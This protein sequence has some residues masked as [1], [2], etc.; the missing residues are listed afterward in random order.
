MKIKFDKVS[1]RYDDDS[2]VLICNEE[3]KL[4]KL[5]N[6]NLK[7]FAFQNLVTHLRS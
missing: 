3:G 2:V 4:K 6:K 1:F 7:S 5:Q